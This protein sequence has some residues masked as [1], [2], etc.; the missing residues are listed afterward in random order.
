MTGSPWRRRLPRVRT[1]TRHPETGLP[2]VTATRPTRREYWSAI[3]LEL[4]EFVRNCWRRW[5]SPEPLWV[6]RRRG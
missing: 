2:V 6:R 1:L 5:R 4:A 3:A